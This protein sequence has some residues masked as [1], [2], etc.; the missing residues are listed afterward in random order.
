VVGDA[1]LSVV[2]A[3]VA[4]FQRRREDAQVALQNAI[5]AGHEGPLPDGASSIDETA[6]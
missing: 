4:S 2:E 1:R 6:A 3:W 5:D